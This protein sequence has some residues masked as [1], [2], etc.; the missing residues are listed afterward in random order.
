MSRF[1]IALPGLVALTVFG[2]AITSASA[3]DYYG[4]GYYGGGYRSSGENVWYS[5]SC[6]YRKV[7]RHE[8]TVHYVR[9]DGYY[10]GGYRDGYY[11][12]SAYRSSY[13]VAPRRYDYDT[14]WGGRYGSFSSCTSRVRVADG[15]G[16][17]VWAT[18]SC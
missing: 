16:G 12:G 3:G 11:G 17:W 7:V 6:C 9:N 18:S 13:Y 5:S 2:A 10:G 1:S 15:F 4:G 14:G 8:R